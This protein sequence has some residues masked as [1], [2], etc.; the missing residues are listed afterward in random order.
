MN[1][2]R[3]ALSETTIL[4]IT[5]EKNSCRMSSTSIYI[6]NEENKSEISIGYGLLWLD[7]TPVS[8]Q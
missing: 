6:D 3:S 8:L 4:D 5:V 7:L 1:R 2:D